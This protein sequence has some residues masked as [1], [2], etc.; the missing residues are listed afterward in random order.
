MYKVDF[1]SGSVSFFLLFTALRL[2]EIIFTFWCRFMWYSVSR[3]ILK[4]YFRIE[5]GICFETIS[6]SLNSYFIY[7]GLTFTPADSCLWL[8]TAYIS[9]IHTVKT[10]VYFLH[11]EFHLSMLVFWV[12]TPCGLQGRYQRFEGTYC[13][14]HQSWSQSS[15]LL[16]NVGIYLEV[17]TA[18]QPRRPTSTS[19]PPWEL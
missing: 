16:P 12:V 17:R 19:S 4:T 8:F 7:A 18:L 6:F 14:H 1:D 5:C 15:I 11:M 10:N 9:S 13:L 2:M 3:S